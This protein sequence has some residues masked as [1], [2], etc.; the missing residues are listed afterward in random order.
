M[1]RRAVTGRAEKAPKKT[2]KAKPQQLT[3]RGEHSSVL[4]KS[5]LADPPA[6]AKRIQLNRLGTGA[7]FARIATEFRSEIRQ[8]RS[9][10]GHFDALFIGINV[11]EWLGEVAGTKARNSGRTNRERA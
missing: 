10:R 11:I 5:R 2:A 7:P 8:N 1:R 3:A 4:M 6:D 9:I